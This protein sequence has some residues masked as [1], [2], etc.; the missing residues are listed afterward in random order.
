M[1]CF[2]YIILQ[3]LEKINRKFTFFG[4]NKKRVNIL[5]SVEKK[6]KQ[7]YNVRSLND[8]GIL[9]IKI[10]DQEEELICFQIQ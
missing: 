5:K 3:N 2:E 9:K 7:C 1:L 10:K 4:K 8:V 6:R